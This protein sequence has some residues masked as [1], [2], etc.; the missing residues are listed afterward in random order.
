M[1]RPL[2]SEA[3]ALSGARELAVRSRRAQGLPDYVTD[4]VTLDYVARL[5]ALTNEL[6]RAGVPP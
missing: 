2:R 6:P 3:S 1:Y 4:T 5:I